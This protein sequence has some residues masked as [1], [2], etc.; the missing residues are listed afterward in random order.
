MNED[1]EIRMTL[2]LPESLRD[3][4]KVWAD[5]SG[6][7]MNA[8]IVARLESS[9]GEDSAEVSEWKKRFEVEREAF[10]RMERLYD[11]TFDVAM[12][13]RELMRTTKG[14][15]L[16]Y[17]GML[18]SLA[19]TILHL[20]GPPPP[21]LISIA[22]RMEAAATDT[23]ERLTEDTDLERAREE[24]RNIDRAVV[25]ADKLLKKSEE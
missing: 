19:S 23:K 9:G 3:R 25:R 5:E 8:E 6:R 11:N 22:E 1:D 15:L 10:T 20:D 18:R 17:V 4:L 24:M 21:D 16:Q 12:N 2:R 14:Q 7:S 13:Y